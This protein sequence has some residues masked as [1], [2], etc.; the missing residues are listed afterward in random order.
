[1]EIVLKGLQEARLQRNIK[2]DLLALQVEGYCT[3]PQHH[4]KTEDFDDAGN[5][6]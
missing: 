3:L 5:A 4:R 1:M 2:S 6:G